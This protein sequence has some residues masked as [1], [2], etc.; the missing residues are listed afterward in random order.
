MSSLWAKAASLLR[1]GQPCV[2]VE[3]VAAEGS[4]PREAGA[5][6]LV[7]GRGFHGT[8]GG[9][10]LEW[11]ALAEA[12]KLLGRAHSIRTLT[13]TL[14]PDLGQCCGGRVSLRLES[15]AVA[16]LALAEANATPEAKTLIH[17]WGA[18]HVGRA[19]VMALAPLPFRVEWW[20]VR[21]GAFPAAMP[22]NVTCRIGEA[23]DMAGPGLVLVMTH[24][25]ALDFAIVDHALRQPG[26]FRVGLIGSETKRVRFE[27][28]LRE[29]GH[30]PANLARLTCPI[31]DKSIA[32]KLPA[33][34]AASVAVQMLHWDQLLKTGL[35]ASHPSLQSAKA[36]TP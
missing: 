7:T 24:S 8:I 36:M 21:E 33:A 34:I 35:G 2:V 19:L 30:P 25:H 18:G 26:F 13:K 22:E 28:R 10:T 3:V 29:A 9:G 23:Q 16:D 12:Q 27:K 4:T 31:G 17:L 20:D 14:G 5:Q 6:M 15:L 11:Q 1:T 32:S